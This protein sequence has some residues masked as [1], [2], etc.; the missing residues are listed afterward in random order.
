MLRDIELDT[1]TIIDGAA[2]PGISMNASPAPTLFAGPF[3]PAAADRMVSVRYAGG[4]AEPYL[5]EG[6]VLFEPQ[7]QVRVRGEPG[8]Y[9]DA[10]LLAMACFEA[11]YMPAVEGY[12]SI[13][14]EGAAPEY[15]GPDDKSRPQ[16]AF[17][18]QLQYVA[19][20]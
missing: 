1:A 8:K 3:P 10:L 9:R 16:F 17:T 20:R 7:V 13:R 14:P 15:L 5:E 2:I 6:R 18:V 19:A 4:E 11:L 12:V